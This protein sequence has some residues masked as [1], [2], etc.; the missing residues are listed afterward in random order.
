MKGEKGRKKGGKR[1]EEKVPKITAA[2]R[3]NVHVKWSGG[4]QLLVIIYILLILFIQGRIK[5]DGYKKDRDVK[6]KSNVHLQWQSM[7]F[8]Q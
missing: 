3:K 6:A 5:D 7:K 4:N 1:K 2:K 8:R